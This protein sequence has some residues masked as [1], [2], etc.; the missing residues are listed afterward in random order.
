[1]GYLLDTSICV[2]FLRGKLNLDRTV[3]QV[4]LEN[5]YISEITVAELRFGAENSDD[6]VKSN[7]AVDIFLKGLTILP[8][9]GSIKRYAIEKVRLRKIGKPINDEFDLLIGVTA[10]ENQLILVTD[11]TKDFK[12]LDGIQMENWFERN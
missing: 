11:N 2:F 5:C 8:I 1:M 6:P 9:F 10:I 12:L 3:K 4:G 7:K